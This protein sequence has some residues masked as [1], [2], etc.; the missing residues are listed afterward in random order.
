MKRILILVCLLFTLI[1]ANA[2]KKQNVYYLKNSGLEVVKDS[3]DFVRVIQEPD[4]GETNFS[5]LE[6]HMNGKRKTLGKVSA[7][8]PNIVMEGT[9]VRFNQEGKRIE[10]TPYENGIPIGMSYHYF[11][12]GKMY[13]QIEYGD[14]TVKLER[15]V[16][17]K[18]D[19]ISPSF[20]PNPNSKLIFMA[21]SLGVVYVKDGNGHLKDIDATTKS[22]KTAEGDYKNGVKDGIWRGSETVPNYSYVETYEMGKLITGESTQGDQKY[23]YST[24]LFSPPQ[25]N[26]GV[27]NFYN[28]IAGSL[29]YPERAIRDK[30]TGKVLIGYTVGKDG[31]VTDVIAK[32][33]A[34]PALDAEAI[35]I[36]WASPKWIPATERGIPTPVKY[37]VPITFS[38]G[39]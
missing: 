21:D 20:S 13:K 6:Y 7:F 38:M 30:A 33:S 19:Y 4:S 34:H 17:P 8:E 15:N 11:D 2:Q 22:V 29:R 18:I 36:V 10:I 32:K 28:H 37:T 16:G 5:Y 9:I 31:K 14:F 3:A 35:R 12:N 26:G 27:E 25:F 1:A 39:R 23:A 24:S